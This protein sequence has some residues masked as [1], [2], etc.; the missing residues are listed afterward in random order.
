MRT[1][2]V[3]HRRGGAGQSGCL[4]RRG[5][6]PT[7]DRW[8]FRRSLEDRK[9]VVLLLKAGKSVHLF[10]EGT[11]VH[12]AELRPFRLGAFET[13]VETGGSR[14]PAAE[15]RSGWRVRTGG[16]GPD[17]CAP[18]GRKE[19]TRGRLCEGRSIRPS[20]PGTD[21]ALFPGLANR[22][23]KQNPCRRF[24][25]CIA[26]WSSIARACWKLSRPW[27]SSARSPRRS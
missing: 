3:G 26:S 20:A 4:M 24:R 2:I 14:G 8:D 1:D 7:V 5:G 17:S 18:A 10:P 12:G 13:A 23:R 25:G 9:R 21:V 6:H 16:V 22:L 15:A 27:I 19:A 11:F